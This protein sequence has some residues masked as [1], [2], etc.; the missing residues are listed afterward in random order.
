MTVAQSPSEFQYQ[1]DGV[2]TQ[3]PVLC[4]FLDV[5]FIKAA[6]E[7]A[8]GT[9]VS[10][11]EG[12]DY[13]VSGGETDA[14]GTLTVT[15]PQPAAVKLQIRRETRIDQ[16][17]DYQNG[18]RFPA[19]SHEEVVDKL[20]MIVQDQQN[21]IGRAVLAPFGEN[22]ITLPR[23]AVRRGKYLGF[24]LIDGSPIAVEGTGTDGVLRGELATASRTKGATLI[25]TERGDTLQQRLR[26]LPTPRPLPRFNAALR[27]YVESG[28]APSVRICGDSIAESSGS[29]SGA[30]KWHFKLFVPTQVF[31][32][33]P[34]RQGETCSLSDIFS[35]PGIAVQRNAIPGASSP[36]A[37]A[38]MAHLYK[39]HATLSQFD[40]LVKPNPSIGADLLILSYGNNEYASW[41]GMAKFAWHYEETIRAALA[42]GVEVV[43]L[44]PHDRAT[45]VVGSRTLDRTIISRS[46]DIGLRLAQYYGCAVVNMRD[47]FRQLVDDG[48]QTVDQLFPY[49]GDPYGYAATDNVHCNNLGLEYY[50]AEF[51]PLFTR[52][53]DTE[54][55]TVAAPVPTVLPK[56]LFR[57]ANYFMNVNRWKLV[58]DRTSGTGTVTTATHP[59]N[60]RTPP[61]FGYPDQYLMMTQAGDEANFRLVGNGLGVLFSK[62]AVPGSAEVLVNGVKV[63]DTV[64][65]NGESEKEYLYWV[66]SNVASQQGNSRKVDVKVRWVSGQIGVVG[67]LVSDARNAGH[68]TYSTDF[69]TL[70][71]TWSDN[72]TFKRTSTQNDYVEFE[73]I[74]TGMAL[75]MP[76]GPAYGRVTV[77]V[78]GV[79]SHTIDLYSV[80]SVSTFQFLVAK[81]LAWGRHTIR[82]TV[83]DKNASSSGYTFDWRNLTMLDEDLDRTSYSTRAVTGQTLSVPEDRAGRITASTPGAAGIVTP[84]TRLLYTTPL[85]GPLGG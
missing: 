10:L 5:S 67:I 14:G 60:V 69:A 16:Q 11:T 25:R 17:T 74:G 55:P 7:L 40:E 79:D 41:E 52:F 58:L 31:Q 28:Y 36:L 73:V 49:V 19:E 9:L 4:R 43:I 35:I 12:V 39:P 68:L 77:R 38:R 44:I 75:D 48:I 3:F 76:M 62:Q 66:A 78:D 13:S 33:L 15:T 42:R 72:G 20:T 6:R 53:G 64:V 85:F 51:L 1:E 54:F 34:G 47:R 37:L 84:T 57:Q 45:G 27:A 81:G 50:A 22:T 8:D 18:D 63:G 61:M 80:G 59:G 23:D 21:S 70:T 46:Q 82:L 2:T 56:R 30:T 26:A 71:G 29:T 65:F 24:S 83:A 32:L